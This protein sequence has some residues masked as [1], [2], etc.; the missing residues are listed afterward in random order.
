MTTKCDDI[1]E[2]GIERK[3]LANVLICASGNRYELPATLVAHAE[4]P[5]PPGFFVE[6][7]GGRGSLLDDVIKK[8]VPVEVCFRTP[9]ARVYFDTYILQKKKNFWINKQI[10]VRYP[11]AI[12]AIEQRSSGRECIPEHVRLLAQLTEDASSWCSV[13]D[14]SEGGASVICPVDRAF[15]ALQPGSVLQV[16]FTLD[17]GRPVRVSAQHR[18]TQQLSA[19]S[20]RVG[21]QF[22]PE[23]M[24]PEAAKPFRQMLAEVERLRLTRS[25][26]HTLRK[27][28]N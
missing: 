24:P 12:Q 9:E 25:L 10:L 4:L 17:G 6:V 22:S 26:R 11:T 28:F 14:I 7:H 13:L 23:A 15:T 27:F 8:S 21:L 16:S 19:N 3:V 5:N 1:L 2:F 18:Y 20:L